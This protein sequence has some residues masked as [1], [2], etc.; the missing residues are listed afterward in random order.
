M[1][2]IIDWWQRQEVN[3]TEMTR[4]VS[5][6]A[7]FLPN[8]RIVNRRGNKHHLT[9]SWVDSEGHVIHK[10]RFFEV[11][12]GPINT[13]YSGPFK[14]YL[15]VLLEIGWLW[16]AP[17]EMIDKHASLRPKQGSWEMIEYCA[18]GALTN[19]HHRILRRG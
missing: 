17:Q 16:G 6:L 18:T 4:E 8:G 9:W 11:P 10:S 19:S 3:Q 13:N 5:V 1:A 14:R 15:L 2:L 12:H 7:K